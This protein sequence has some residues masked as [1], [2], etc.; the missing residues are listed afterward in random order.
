MTTPLLNKITKGSVLDIVIL[1]V[2]LWQSF[3][4]D[5]ISDWHI[6]WFPPA[7]VPHLTVI[8]PK[9]HITKVATGR[10]PTVA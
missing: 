6:R 1:S 5:T 9:N 3:D 8:P 10:F 7:I 2:C 4:V